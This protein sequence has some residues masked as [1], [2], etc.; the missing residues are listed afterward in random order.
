M[1]FHRGKVGKF[2]RKLELDIRRIMEPNTAL[3]L[4][5]GFLIVR[6]FL[7]SCYM[8]RCFLLHFRVL[9]WKNCSSFC[10]IK[11]LLLLSMLKASNFL[12]EFFFGRFMKNGRKSLVLTFFVG[13][14]RG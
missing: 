3:K 4:K 8:Y 11:G 9:Y 6:V 13:N 7:S 14:K 5:V 1:V 2:L 10:E 12:H